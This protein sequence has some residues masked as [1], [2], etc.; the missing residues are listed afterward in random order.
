[1]GGDQGAKGEKGEKGEKGDRGNDG[2]GLKLK[3]FVLGQIYNHGDY[4]FSKSSKDNHDS[5]YIA[6]RTFNATKEPRFDMDSGNWVEFHAPRG[7]DGM[8][9]E[10]GEKGNDSKKGDRGITGAQ[11]EKGTTGAQGM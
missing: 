3:D 7:V 5:M 10:K 9:G 1:M 2:T 8:K 4:V 11:G 6:E